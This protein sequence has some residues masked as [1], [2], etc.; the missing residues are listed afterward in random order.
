MKSYVATEGDT[1]S[2]EPVCL[3]DGD[4]E[5]NI[6]DFGGDGL[7]N[8]NGKGHY[9]VTTSNG[10]LIAEGGEFERQESTSFSI[11]FGGNHSQSDDQ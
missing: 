7:Y 10:Q 5:F 9:N 4:Y 1:S 11:P 6:L 2:T 3:Q 8:Y